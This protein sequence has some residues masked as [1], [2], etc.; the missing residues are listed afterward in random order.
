MY[1]IDIKDLYLN[2]SKLILKDIYG[3]PIS[4]ESTVVE[5]C[6]FSNDL[7]VTM[8]NYSPDFSLRGFFRKREGSRSEF[9][10]SSEGNHT[11]F[12]TGINR[13]TVSLKPF[14]IT[15][16]EVVYTSIWEQNN[17]CYLFQIIKN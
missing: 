6:N 7:Y 12:L 17:L 8:G 3:I 2:K 13:E 15:D 16:K 5:Y 4:Y 11:L 14:K 1:A 10:I 9:F